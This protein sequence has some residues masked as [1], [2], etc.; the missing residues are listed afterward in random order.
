M[1]RATFKSWQQEVVLITFNPVMEHSPRMRETLGQ[2]PPLPSP[3]VEEG[4]DQGVLT[5]LR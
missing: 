3:K 5:H 2:L 1:D 4:F